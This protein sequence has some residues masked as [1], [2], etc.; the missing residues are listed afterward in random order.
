MKKAMSKVVL[1]CFSLLWAHSS[2]VAANSWYLTDSTVYKNYTIK[3]IFY[4]PH[5][6]N[7][8]ICAYFAPVSSGEPISA[9]SV[10]D[11][12][13]YS[14]QTEAAAPVYPS[15]FNM[16]KLFYVT[17]ESVNIYVRKNMFSE[18]DTSLS[19]HELVGIGSCNGWCFG[20]R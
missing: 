15:I 8:R 14:K 4:A 1:F 10:A 2:L 12:G 16:V 18:M 19:K 11:L 5:G 7:P 20:E 3:N 6:I 13:A 9:C 17:G